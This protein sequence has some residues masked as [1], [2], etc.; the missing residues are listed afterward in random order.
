[1]YVCLHSHPSINPRS[2]RLTSSFGLFSFLFSSNLVVV[3]EPYVF[4]QELHD[5]EADWILNNFVP[6]A[7][8]FSASQS[9]EAVD[10]VSIHSFVE[11][12]IVTD[13]M[14]CFKENKNVQTKAICFALAAAESMFVKWKLS[15]KVEDDLSKFEAIFVLPSSNTK[16]VLVIS[17]A[18]N[19]AGKD[20]Y[21]F[22]MN[23]PDLTIGKVFEAF[24]IP[25]KIDAIPGFSSVA[26]IKLT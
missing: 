19:A 16:V 22:S 10:T 5:Q 17:V 20:E 24:P 14:K 7:E 12:D 8:G 25:I 15:L 26:A 9:A 18:K 2:Y 1:M 6:A 23:A 11:A 13:A 4:Q 3:S 21:T